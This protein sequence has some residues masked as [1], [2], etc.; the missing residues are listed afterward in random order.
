MILIGVAGYSHSKLILFALL[1][2]KKKKKKIKKQKK[3]KEKKE[4]NCIYF[5]AY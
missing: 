5:S 4:L 1:L 2:S 3:E